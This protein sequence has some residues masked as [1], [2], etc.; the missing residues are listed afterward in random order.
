MR[1]NWGFEC[2]LPSR[3]NQRQVTESQT[4]TQLHAA[5]PRSLLAWRRCVVLQMEFLENDFSTQ[6][7]FQFDTPEGVR[8]GESASVTVA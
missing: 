4:P 8:I 7:R 1:A 5:F 2:L 6:K 3:A